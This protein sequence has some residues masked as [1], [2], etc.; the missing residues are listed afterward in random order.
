[1]PVR[2]AKVQDNNTPNAGEAME[3]QQLSG[4][5]DGNTKWYSHF[6]NGLVNSY[7]HT[8]TIYALAIVVFTQMN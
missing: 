6:G 2:I 4:I 8:L 1:M 3:Q 5:A 7:K